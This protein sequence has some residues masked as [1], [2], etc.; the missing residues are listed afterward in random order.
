MQGLDKWQNAI[1]NL[2]NSHEGVDYMSYK[3]TLTNTLTLLSLIILD[4]SHSSV[5]HAQFSVPNPLPGERSPLKIVSPSGYT[6]TIKFFDVVNAAIDIGNP[7]DIPGPA[8]NIVTTQQDGVVSTNQYEL[9]PLPG[10]PQ[11]DPPYTGG[12][13]GATSAR[14]T[15]ST[16]RIIGVVGGSMESPKY[17][18]STHFGA[19]EVLTATGNPPCFRYILKGPATITVNGVQ[20]SNYT[21]NVWVQQ[22]YNVNGQAGRPTVLDGFAQVSGSV[23][24]GLLNVSASNS[25]PLANENTGWVQDIMQEDQVQVVDGTGTL[26]INAPFPT[27]GG[28]CGMSAFGQLVP[29]VVNAQLYYVIKP[30]EIDGP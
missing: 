14:S 11:Y 1:Y 18:A 7:I 8:L 13:S 21:V 4:M 10:Q 16:V 23:G 6:Y 24:G 29:M 2:N 19:T 20:S 22:W 25:K 15:D 3:V 30:V 28:K 27:F 12:N 9:Y 17:A 5:C 26:L